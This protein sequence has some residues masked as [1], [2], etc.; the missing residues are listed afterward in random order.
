MAT[1]LHSKGKGKAVEQSPAKSYPI[2]QAFAQVTRRKPSSQPSSPGQ[3]SST[4]Q[5]LRPH[6]Q[7]G[8]RK[9]GQSSV[10]RVLN[11]QQVYNTIA[12]VVTAF[13]KNREE[14]MNEKHKS[15]TRELKLS[16]I[17]LFEHGVSINKLHKLIDVDRKRIKYWISIKHEIKASKS[18]S[19]RVSSKGGKAPQYPELE[20]ELTARFHERRAAGFGVNRRW[21]KRIAVEIYCDMYGVEFETIA[22]TQFSLGWF[23]RYRKRWHISYRKATKTASKTPEDFKKKIISFLQYNRRA[24]QPRDGEPVIPGGV[25]RFDLS[26]IANMDQIPLAFDHAKGYTYA[27]TGSRSVMARNSKSGWEKRCATLQC[28]VFADGINRMKPT[29]MFKGKP[30]S[31]TRARLAELRLY[32]RRVKVIFNDKAYANTQTQ[33]EYAKVSYYVNA[34]LGK[35]NHKARSTGLLQQATSHLPHLACSVWTSSRARRMSRCL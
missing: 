27:A 33:L 35:A 8:V 18:K 19:F 34:G 9:S 22:S 3:E 20:K 16:T 28:T 14:Q 17:E 2:V 1:A 11:A 10:Q 7:N 24:Q 21:F 29:I 4:P 25:G 6:G 32:D 12:R 5:I 31:R 30:N 15:Y 13:N 26:A 23:R